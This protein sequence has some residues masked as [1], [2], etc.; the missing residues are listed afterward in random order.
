[1]KVHR[2]RLV[3]VVIEEHKV[4]K[5]LTETVVRKD[6]KVLEVNQVYVEKMEHRV[7]LVHVVMLVHK[8][9]LVKKVNKVHK[10]H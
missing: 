3:N 1:M 10:V 9:K 8:V 5:D 2:V 4:N 6:D 7:N